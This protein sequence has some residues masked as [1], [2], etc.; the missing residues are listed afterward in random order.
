[1]LEQPSINDANYLALEFGTEKAH[2]HWNEA[3]I[4]RIDDNLLLTENETL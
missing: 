1:M 4:N 3:N 2:R